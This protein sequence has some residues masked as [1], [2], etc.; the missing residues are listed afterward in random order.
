MIKVSLF[1]METSMH[2]R[3][4]FF[5]E[6]YSKTREKIF[7]FIYKL[8]GN[9]DIAMELMQETFTNFYD[10]YSQKLKDQTESTRFNFP[11]LN[12]TITHIKY[13]SWTTFD[14]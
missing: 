9:E 11:I 8:V 5:E 2:E 1:C 12:E 6:L 7:E 14:R 10:S 13:F 4:K 3:D